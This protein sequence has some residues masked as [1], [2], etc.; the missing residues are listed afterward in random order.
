MEKTGIKPGKK[1]ESGNGGERIASKFYAML[2]IGEQ[3]QKLQ[4]TVEN[5]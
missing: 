4:K 3:L 1:R 2:K 5:C